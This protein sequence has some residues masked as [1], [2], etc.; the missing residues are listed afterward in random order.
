MLVDKV[1]HGILVSAAA[2]NPVF[3]AIGPIS[4]QT[5]HDQP[6]LSCG[7]IDESSNDSFPYRQCRES[8]SRNPLIAQLMME[9]CVS[10]MI[11][12]GKSDVRSIFPEL[13]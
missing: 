11:D 2:G 7:N 4:H 3:D 9:R 10:V 13:M 12:G 1:E 6:F 5:R 8:F